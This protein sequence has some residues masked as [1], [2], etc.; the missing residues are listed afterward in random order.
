M[1]NRHT[2]KVIK[3][4]FLELCRQDKIYFPS[5][6][7]PVDNKKCI[8]SKEDGFVLGWNQGDGWVCEHIAQ[9]NVLQYGFI[10]NEE[11]L[12]SGIGQQI[13]NYTN[14]LAK[15]ESTLRQDHDTK[16]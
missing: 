16:S 2:G 3:K 14:K 12:K 5:F 7:N 1:I 11:D 15:K 10:F 9:N 4:T 6:E 8:F 13:L